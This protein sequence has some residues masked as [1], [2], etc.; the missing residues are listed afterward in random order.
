M[1]DPFMILVLAVPL[2]CVTALVIYMITKVKKLRRDAEEGRK[3][4]E[5]AKNREE[6]QE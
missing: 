6:T 4:A 2:I 1:I 5:A 3:K